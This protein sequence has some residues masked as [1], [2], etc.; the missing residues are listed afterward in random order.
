VAQPRSSNNT[1]E[2]HSLWGA[3]VLSAVFH[4]AALAAAFFIW[5]SLSPPIALP[6]DI[7]PVDLEV[8]DQTNVT[9][10]EQAPEPPPEQQALPI[11]EPPEP[12]FQPSTE[13]PP[14]PPEDE[15]A[16]EEDK[17]EPPPEDIKPVP[18]PRFAM[19]APRAKPKPEKKNEDFDIDKI[20]NLVDKIEKQ[21]PK[22]ESK[23]QPSP[24]QS[25]RSTTGA[26]AQSAM[27]ASEID[28][29]KS[30]LRKCWNV[31]VGAPDPAALVF[32][33][34]IFLN[35]DGTVAAEPELI[36]QGGMAD[37]HFRAAVD[38]A[39]RAVHICSP[40]QLPAEKFASWNEITITFDPTKMSGY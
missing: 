39:K 35:P 19:A 3:A 32:R 34:R 20:T 40:F 8:A 17:T 36:D 18:Q 5:P 26:G 16:L 37:P 23:S 15:L 4:A 7:V 38:S 30:Q 12:Q 10:Q 24:P 11:P 25:K 13:P 6:S 21:T 9:P 14:P 1:P 27:T 29:F 2:S 33:V 22:A 28:A 31:P